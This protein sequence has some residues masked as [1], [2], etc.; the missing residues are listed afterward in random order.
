[1]VGNRRM[2]ARTRAVVLVIVLAATASAVSTSVAAEARR[3]DPASGPAPTAWSAG[4][5]TTYGDGGALDARELVVTDDETV[6]YTS[7]IR[8][9]VTRVA[10]DG[11][12]TTYDDPHIDW[13]LGITEA[14]DG[15]IWFANHRAND[16]GRIAPDGSLSFVADPAEQGPAWPAIGSDGADCW[17]IARKTS[18]GAMPCS[19]SRLAKRRLRS[20][21]SAQLHV[22]PRQIRHGRSPSWAASASWI[23]ARSSSTLS[24]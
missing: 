23:A 2:P 3:P 21:T 11:G 4:A 24:R 16:L 13:P 7:T 8:D 5:T 1:M 9:T 18:A 17:W 10:P 15:S 19:S 20:V 6:W 14:P 22:R 12:T